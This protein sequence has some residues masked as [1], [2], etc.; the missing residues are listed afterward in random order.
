MKV[1]NNLKRRLEE[2][3]IKNMIP[4]G[5]L[6]NK[7]LDG[8]TIIRFNKILANSSKNELTAQEVRTLTKWLANM[9]GQPEAAI[10]LLEPVAQEK[11]VAR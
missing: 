2:L 5:D 6:L 7:H 10:E 1:K 4:T 11:E 8:M 9:T 3:G